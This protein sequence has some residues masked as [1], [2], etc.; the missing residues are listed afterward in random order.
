MV[1][2][3]HH[4]VW[5]IAT[6]AARLPRGRPGRLPPL[7]CGR[8]LRLRR[9]DRRP[10][11]CRPR[12]L[13]LLPLL[14]LLGSLSL[15]LLLALLPPLLGLRG[16]LLLGAPVRRAFRAVHPQPRVPPHA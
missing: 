15:R 10:R 9:Q 6:Q 4:T 2:L 3:D 14:L 13:L 5:P 8:R 12:L 16:G 1:M 7:L 11:N